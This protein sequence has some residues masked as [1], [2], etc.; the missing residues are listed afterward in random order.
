MSEINSCKVPHK[1]LLRNHKSVVNILAEIAKEYEFVQK[2]PYDPGC[3]SLITL[4][5]AEVSTHVDLPE[6]VVWDLRQNGIINSP[7]TSGD[8]DFLH[9]YRQALDEVSVAESKKHRS[10]HPK[11]QLALDEPWQ[12]WVYLRYLNNRIVYN[13]DRSMMNPSKRIF[14]RSLAKDVELLFAVTR[15]PELMREIKAIRVTAYNDKRKALDRE[16]PLADV[17]LQRGVGQEMIQANLNL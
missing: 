4:S 8:V 2:G 5:L 6:D 1:R 9:R 14:V 16:Q 15:N 11:T 17:A 10:R 13:S 7:I 3:E 12:I